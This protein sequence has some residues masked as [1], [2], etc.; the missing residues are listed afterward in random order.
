[1]EE[2]YNDV[3]VRQSIDGTLRPPI[4]GE[5]DREELGFTAAPVCFSVPDC[6]N[7]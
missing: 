3:D 4:G 6:A 5:S 2:L 7:T 1:M